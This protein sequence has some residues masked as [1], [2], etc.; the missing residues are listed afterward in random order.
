MGNSIQTQRRRTTAKMNLS[1]SYKRQRS[2]SLKSFKF[3][4]KFP[5]A[6]CI[7]PDLSKVEEFQQE[8]EDIQNKLDNL[9]TI[10]NIQFKKVI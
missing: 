4:T 7:Q 5:F 10:N 6:E 8:I 1:K 9:S 3:K 2:Y